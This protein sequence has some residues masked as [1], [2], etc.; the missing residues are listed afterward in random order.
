RKPIG[1][2]RRGAGHFAGASSPCAVS[3]ES[4]E[5]RRTTLNRSPS[6]VS[7]RVPFW[8]SVRLRAMERPRP[9]PSPPRAASPRTNRSS[10]SSAGISNGAREVF[11]KEITAWPSR[12][13]SVRYTRVPRWAYLQMLFIRLSN[14]RH[15]RR[16]SARMVTAVSGCRVTRSRPASFSFCSYS[17]AAWVS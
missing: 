8:S 1:K 14:T 17:P 10:S 16:P 5:N 3:H 4:S 15:S 13:S 9:F 6:T 7:S 12:S 2:N 11:L